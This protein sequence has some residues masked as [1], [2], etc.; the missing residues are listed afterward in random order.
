[1][2]T[3]IIGWIYIVGSAVFIFLSLPGFLLFINRYTNYGGSMTFEVMR[4]FG[5]SIAA[6]VVGIFSFFFGSA[7]KAKK[8]WAWYVGMAVF[9]LLTLGSLFMLIMQGF[10]AIVPVIFQMFFVYSLLD[11]KQ[12]FFAK[13]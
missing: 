9:T 12:L 10:G 6:L 2:K 8:K 5:L 11:E 3:K 4:M 13:K 1:M 7:L